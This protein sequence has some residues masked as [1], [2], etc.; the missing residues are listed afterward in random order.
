MSESHESQTL[1]S[2]H[3]HRL[4]MCYQ[5]YPCSYLPRPRDVGKGHVQE[6]HLQDAGSQLLRLDGRAGGQVAN[7]SVMPKIVEGR[8][9]GVVNIPGAE[10]C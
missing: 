2:T 7:V 6:E 3:L 4:F 1:S 8:T 10:I 5:C 9:Q